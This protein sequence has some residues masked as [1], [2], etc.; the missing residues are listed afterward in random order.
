MSFATLDKTEGR[1]Q[2]WRERTKLRKTMGSPKMSKANF[3]GGKNMGSPKMSEANFWG[4]KN[5][6]SPKMSEANFGGWKTD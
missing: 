5:M 6:G 2:G 3:W 4:G 1:A